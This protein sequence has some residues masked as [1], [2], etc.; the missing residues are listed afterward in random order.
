MQ[1]DTEKELRVP[2]SEIQSKNKRATDLTV[3]STKDRFY[4]ENKEGEWVDVTEK[5]NGEEKEN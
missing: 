5:W 1:R 4:Q 3:F 2:A